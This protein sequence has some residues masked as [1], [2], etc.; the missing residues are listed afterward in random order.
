MLH[1][2]EVGDSSYVTHERRNT[3]VTQLKGE[4]VSEMGLILS[5]SS[6]VL[7]GYK[8]T[9]TTLLEPVKVFLKLYT[10]NLSGGQRIKA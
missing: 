4:A 5:Y 10:G 2:E 1:N 8:I 7:L 9:V 3:N 6:Q